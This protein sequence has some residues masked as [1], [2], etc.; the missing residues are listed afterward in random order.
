M[1]SIPA[2]VSAG[3]WGVVGLGRGGVGWGEAAGVAM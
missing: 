2:S 1:D 3:C